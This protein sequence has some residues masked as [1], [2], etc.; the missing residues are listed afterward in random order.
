MLSVT[1][2]RNHEPSQTKVNVA[3]A[4]QEIKRDLV[5]TAAGGSTH[6]ILYRVL[7]ALTGEERLEFGNTQS[8]KR[9]FNRY[10]AKGRPRDPAE[11]HDLIIEGRWLQDIDGNEFLIY[12]NLNHKNRMIV[13]G[14]DQCLVHLAN[15]NIWHMDGTFKMCPTLFEQLYVI[16]TPLDVYDK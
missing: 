13:F 1:V 6:Q 16:R 8:A 15:S 2:H 11:L 9:S 12:D 3:A 14:T 5:A 7:Y 4:K 10:I